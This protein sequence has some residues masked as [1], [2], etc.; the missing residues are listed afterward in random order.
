M[1][2]ASMQC[3]AACRPLPA[4]AQAKRSRRQPKP[5]PK[6]RPP[7]QPSHKGFGRHEQRAGAPNPLR[8]GL[9]PAQQLLRPFSRRTDNPG[10]QLDQVQ[11]DSP[12]PWQPPFDWGGLKLQGP[13]EAAEGRVARMANALLVPEGSPAVYVQQ[14]LWRL[15]EYR[16]PAYLQALGC[17][18][19]QAA[20]H[21]LRQWW[22]TLDDMEGWG[23]ATA[24]GALA[25]VSW[26]VLAWRGLPYD[27]GA[28]RVLRAAASARA[29]A[30]TDLQRSGLTPCRRR[31]RTWRSW[32]TP[33]ASLA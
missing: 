24:Y 22:E 19:R 16:H 6:P 11:L 10:K 28:L 23:I 4:V 20:A 31:R 29:A 2:L 32:R 17:S 14:Q 33:P 21:A 12:L 8:K 18:P 9:E 3:S 5:K 13:L 26:A 7:E 15:L 1:M 27:R 25:R 30:R